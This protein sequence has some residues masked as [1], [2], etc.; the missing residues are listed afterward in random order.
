MRGRVM[1]IGMM[2]FGLMPLGA[3]PFGALAE[4]VGTYNALTLSGILLAVFTAIFAIAYPKFKK[5]A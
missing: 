4:Y 1:S 3:V 2:T 5:I